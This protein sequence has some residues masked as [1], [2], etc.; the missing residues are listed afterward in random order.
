MPQRSDVEIRRAA[1]RFGESARREA[2]RPPPEGRPPA[3]AVGQ[4]LM[5]G[6][7]E[8]EGV[9][10][11]GGENYIDYETAKEFVTYLLVNPCNSDGM[12][13]NTEKRLR[14]KCPPPTGLAGVLSSA[15]APQQG[16]TA[17]HVVG[18][19][20]YDG[21]EPAP[22]EEPYDGLLVLGAGKDGVTLAA[23]LL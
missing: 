4:V 9:K 8:A 14:I 22:D 12:E 6:K 16:V 2:D 3:D 23:A 18:F 19:L 13:V 10:D 5:F 11:S 20:G 1:D 7:V 21:C 17:Q 15:D